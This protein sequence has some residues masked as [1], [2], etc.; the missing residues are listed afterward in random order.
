VARSL[1]QARSLLVLA[2]TLVTP[3]TRSI[4]FV[5]SFAIDVTSLVMVPGKL[6]RNVVTLAIVMR[7]FLTSIRRFVWHTARDGPPT[8]SLAR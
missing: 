2:V 8:E 6:T 7:S 4:R 5:L 3:I 1:A